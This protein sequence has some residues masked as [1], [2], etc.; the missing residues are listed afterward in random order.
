MNAQLGNSVSVKELLQAQ[1]EDGNIGPILC[2]LDSGQL[3][4]DWDQVSH[5][6]KEAKNLWS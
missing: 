5:L 1:Q 6:G 4:P 3:Q 2:H